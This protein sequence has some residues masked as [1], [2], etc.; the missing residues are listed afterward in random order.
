M[1]ALVPAGLEKRVLMLVGELLGLLD[2]EEF[3]HGLLVALREAVPSDWSALNEVP[4]DVPDAISLTDPAVPVALHAAFARYALENPIVSHLMRTGDG[5]AIRFSDL[6]T[7][8]ELHRLD[9]YRHVYQPLRVEYQIAFT[10]TSA[11]ARFLGVA[12]SRSGRDFTV[13]ERDLLNLARPYLIQLY[14]NV[15]AHTAQA[16]EL[17]LDRL[18]GLGLT[19][20][21][22][23]VLQLVARG[24]TAPEAAA[25]LGISARTAQKHLEHCYRTLGVSNRSDAARAAWATADG[26]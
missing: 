6:V 21:Q 18:R 2:L 8:R 25:G 3:S 22:A 26:G 15:I 16:P 19:A 1:I 11:S 5:R 4:A 12:L 13:R 24:S 10:L 14:R 20:R 9:I 7:R 17:R 23:A